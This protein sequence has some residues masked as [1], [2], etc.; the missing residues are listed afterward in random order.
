[1][2]VIGHDE[3]SISRYGAVHKFVIVRVGMN[4]MPVMVSK[5]F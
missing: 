4:E 2:P 5:C 3:I 1:M